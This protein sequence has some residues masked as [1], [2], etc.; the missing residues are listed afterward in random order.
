MVT[1]VIGGSGS[2]KS[3]YAEQL[4]CR[5]PGNRYYIATMEPY[6]G[7]MY[8]RIRR[9]QKMR[10]EK[11]FVTIERYRDLAGLELCAAGTILL[12]C[13]SNLLANELY[14]ACPDGTFSGG[15]RLDEAVAEKIL[16]GIEHVI[17]Q[18]ENLI[19]VSNDMFSSGERYEAETLRYVRLLGRLNQS[20]AVRADCVCEVVCGIPVLWKDLKNMEDGSIAE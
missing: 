12:E 2:G 7:E 14:S 19:I 15:S 3:E 20:L 8:S 9:H 6:D 11:G 4:A 18:C 1:L 16:A 5:E 17:E 10:K 13:M